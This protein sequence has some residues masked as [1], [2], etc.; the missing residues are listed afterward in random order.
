MNQANQRRK[1]MSEQPRPERQPY[2]QSFYPAVPARFTKVMRTNLLWQLFR[3]V[4]LNIKMLRMVR[5]H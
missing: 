3:F 4:I 2:E 5:K 1:A